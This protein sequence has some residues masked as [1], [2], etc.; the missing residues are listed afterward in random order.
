MKQKTDASQSYDASVFCIGAGLDANNNKNNKKGK[1]R[2]RYDETTNCKM[3]R[4]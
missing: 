3:Q 2:R 4:A 1:G